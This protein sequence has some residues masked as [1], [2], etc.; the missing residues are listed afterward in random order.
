MCLPALAPLFT[1]IGADAA[2]TWAAG[3]TIGTS[4]QVLGTVVGIGGTLASGIAQS[5]AA[6]VQIAQ[7]E[8]QKATEAQLNSVREQRSRKMFQ[9]QI[10]QQRAELL[11]RGVSLDSPTAVFLGQT[12]AAEMTFQSQTIRQGG[13]A[14]QNE[15][16]NSQQ[17]LRARS[18]IALLKGGFSA[19]GGL[20]NAAPKLWPE[21]LK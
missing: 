12:A 17:A 10:A 13:L 4:L 3:A 5:R 9:T 1:A 18:N 2:A 20:L 16:S 11:S 15:M 6:N 14:T 21:L 8:T 19:A 7:I